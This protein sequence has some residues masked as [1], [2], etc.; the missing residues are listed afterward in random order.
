ME[1]CEV[2]SLTHVLEEHDRGR[3][4][5][6]EHMTGAETCC[7]RQFSLIDPKVACFVL[8]VQARCYNQGIKD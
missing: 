4:M 2:A 6:V 3:V 1:F 7:F 8:Q 5:D